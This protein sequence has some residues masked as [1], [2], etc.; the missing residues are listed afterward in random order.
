[1]A[2]WRT[3]FI[4]V[5]CGSMLGL[6]NGCAPASSSTLDEENE[7]FTARAMGLERAMDYPSAIE[8]YQRALQVNPQSGT[9]HFRLAFL[10][11]RQ[12]NNPAAAIYHFQQYLKLRPNSEHADVIRQ[13][14]IG[15]KQELAKEFA[16]GPMGEEVKVQLDS[17]IQQNLQLKE[18][19]QKLTE[20]S[21][22]L[23][24]QLN[25]IQPGQ[26]LTE[27]R[28]I[29]PDQNRRGP[30]RSVGAIPPQTGTKTHTVQKGDT[31]YSIARGYGI[32]LS[33]LEGANPGI[34][35]NRLRIGQV[36]AV[37]AP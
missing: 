31:F 25:A 4:A 32:K 28:S 30:D 20:E 15:C 34:N 22:R 24:G 35:P 10:Y 8:A 2:F 18:D 26:E 12:N 36:I 19:N 21:R 3:I 16:I 6:L 13:H 33:A 9:A 5:T 1:M 14:I 11:V 27:V 7:L 17:F 37:P 29:S 23:R